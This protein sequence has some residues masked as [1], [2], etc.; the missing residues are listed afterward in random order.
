L[1]DDISRDCRDN[2][3]HGFFGQIGDRSY[4]LVITSST[5]AI[6]AMAFLARQELQQTIST[7]HTLPMTVESNRTQA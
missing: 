5:P 2:L 3:C 4:S 1:A 6:V 7:L